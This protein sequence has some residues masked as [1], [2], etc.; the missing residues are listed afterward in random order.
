[1]KKLLLI[2]LISVFINASEI[3]D[4]LKEGFESYKNSG[5]KSALKAW[6]KRSP[7]GE[8]NEEALAQS[9]Q[10][11]KLEEL[12]GKF[13][14]YELFKSSSLGSKTTFYLIVMNYEKGALFTRFL[15]YKTPKNKEVLL[16]FKFNNMPLKVWPKQIVY[17]LKD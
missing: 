13:V 17:N 15:I 8:N 3:P 14:D 11:R 9:I 5:A 6:L 1:M 7:I 10:F 2:G 16:S 4:L 12:Y